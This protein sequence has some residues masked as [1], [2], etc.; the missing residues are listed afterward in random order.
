MDEQVSRAAIHVNFLQYCDG[1]N[2]TVTYTDKNG[3]KWEDVQEVTMSAQISG[4]L[5]VER[6]WKLFVNNVMIPAGILSSDTYTPDETVT[7]KSRGITGSGVTSTFEGFDQDVRRTDNIG[8]TVTVPLNT[9]PTVHTT[10]ATK[11]D[12]INTTLAKANQQVAINNGFVDKWTYDWSPSSRS[13]YA[14]YAG[15]T[16]PGTGFSEHPDPE[17]TTKVP[18]FLRSIIK[19]ATS[20]GGGAI[21]VELKPD[22]DKWRVSMPTHVN[23]TVGINDGMDTGVTTYGIGTPCIDHCSAELFVVNGKEDAHGMAD[24]TH[25]TS[26]VSDTDAYNNYTLFKQAG[27][28]RNSHGVF[29]MASDNKPQMTEKVYFGTQEVSNVNDALSGDKQPIHN[30]QKLPHFIKSVWLVLYDD[31]AGYRFN[32]KKFLQYMKNMNIFDGSASEAT[33]NSL[34]YFNMSAEFGFQTVTRHDSKTDAASVPIDPCAYNTDPVVTEGDDGCVMITAQP[35][36]H[37]KNDLILSPS[38]HSKIGSKQNP[39]LPLPIPYADGRQHSS[40]ASRMSDSTQL[41]EYSTCIGQGFSGGVSNVARFIISSRSVATS[42]EIASTGSQSNIIATF[43]PLYDAE[44]KATGDGF[45]VGTTGYPWR[46]YVIMNELNTNA[47]IDVQVQVEFKDDLGKFYPLYMR[48]HDYANI[49]VTFVP[50]GQFE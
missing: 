34:R 35:G 49:G 8:N 33:F 37:A 19:G 27:L 13:L 18:V 28:M 12:N 38:L 24:V 43:S 44:V 21:A 23:V 25:M 29:S 14:D 11:A 1:V 17:F 39:S 50:P 6:G 48:K 22:D 2:D 32:V 4:G 20:T 40:A 46:Q 31:P 10:H 3:V 26:T 5:Q 42:G 36:Y 41:A 15:Y 30:M 7:V 16:N 47:R 9:E 45:T